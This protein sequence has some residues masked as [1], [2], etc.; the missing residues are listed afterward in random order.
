MCTPNYSSTPFTKHTSNKA[1]NSCQNSNKPSAGSS[2]SPQEIGKIVDL[3]V[4]DPSFWKLGIK[5]YEHFLKELE[6]IGN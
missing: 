6:N 3:D 4:N 1:Q 2:I 5:Q